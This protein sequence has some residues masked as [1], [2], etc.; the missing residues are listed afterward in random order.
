[1]GGAARKSR[2]ILN[3]KF[4]RA[5]AWALSLCL[6]FGSARAQSLLPNAEQQFL[7]ANGAPLA[8]GYVYTYIPGTTT[9]KMTWADAGLSVANPNP[10][11]L[12]SSGRATIWGSGSYRQIVQDQNQNLIWDQVTTSALTSVPPPTPTVQA[13]K[14]FTAD[15]A[16]DVTL[17]SV[18]SPII[19]NRFEFDTV[20]GYST[21]S[22]VFSP[23][24]KGQYI[25]TATLYI[26]GT[27]AGGGNCFLGITRNGLSGR[28]VA[29]QVFPGTVS[30]TV[31]G[32]MVVTGIF[33]LNGAGDTA[34]AVANC[35]TAG[36]I[37]ALSG[38]T[39]SYISAAWLGNY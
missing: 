29:S 16:S 27:T 25:I 7:D 13:G 18:L 36:T 30:T 33:Q 37:T 15:L 38:S 22:G 24:L 4:P 32:S 21:T 6:L 5:L 34:Y 3:M 20:G 14:S 1:M 35:N 23:T 28:T 19:F 12:D 17:T 31:F 9:A 26:S 39:V 8:A 10:I 11:R 2:V